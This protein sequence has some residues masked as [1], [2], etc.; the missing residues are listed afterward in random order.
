MGVAVEGVKGRGE[1][2]KGGLGDGRRKGGGGGGNGGGVC[3]RIGRSYHL[4]LAFLF[5]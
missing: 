1:E 4:L 3:G 5:V 2:V